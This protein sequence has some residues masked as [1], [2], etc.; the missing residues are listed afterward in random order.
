MG[1]IVEMLTQPLTRTSQAASVAIKE[2]SYGVGILE[3]QLF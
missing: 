2:Q 3:N 1:F